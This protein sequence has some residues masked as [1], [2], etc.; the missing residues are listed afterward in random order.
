VNL[1]IDDYSLSII[2]LFG[3]HFLLRKFSFPFCKKLYT[4]INIFTKV[5]V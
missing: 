2:F 4:K 3:H 5:I 1:G